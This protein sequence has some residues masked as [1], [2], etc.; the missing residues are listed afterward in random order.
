MLKLREEIKKENLR[1]FG[2]GK[3]FLSKNNKRKNLI[4]WLKLCSSK[5]IY[6]NKKI[7]KKEK[8]KIK[9]HTRGKYL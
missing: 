3:D 2:F 6:E 7:K 5:D 4:N 8:K 1:I 9:L